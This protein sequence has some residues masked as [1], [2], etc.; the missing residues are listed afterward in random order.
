MKK[1]PFYIYVFLLGIAVA[2]AVYYYPVMPDMMASHF[3]GSGKADNF[4][5]KEGFFALY[6]IILVSTAGIFLFMP[7]AFQKFRVQKMNLP[8]PD[9]WLTPARID[10]VYSYFK[11][12][13]CWFGVANLILMVGVVQLVFD[14]NLTPNPVLNNSVFLTLLGGYFV[15][16]IVWLIVFYRKF[17]RID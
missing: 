15:F 17:K 16:V 6:V 7:W 11:T 13:M 1:L 3:A 10:E 5:T 12:S 9:Y 2:Q 8:N 14:A 4:A